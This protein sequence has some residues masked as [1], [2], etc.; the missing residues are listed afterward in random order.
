MKKKITSPKQLIAIFLATVGVLSM[1]LGV[2][3]ITSGG[4]S[5]PN[6]ARNGVVFIY[7]EFQDDAGNAYSA[8]GTGWAIGKPGKDVQYIVTNGHVVQYA[9]LTGGLI[10]VYFSVAENDF[11]VPQVVYYSDPA[12]KDVAIL[13]LPTATDKR[14]ALRL[15]A[16]DQVEAGDTAYALGYPGTSSQRQEYLTYD[17]SDITMT[18]G[19]VSKQMNPSGVGYSAFQMDTYIS[20]GNSGG[21]LVDEDG[22]VIGINTLGAIDPETGTELGMNYAIV[23]DELTKILDSEGMD[24]TMTGSGFGAPWM[25][26]LFL[27]LAVLT[28][29]GAAVLFMQEKKS[30]KISAATS[31]GAKNGTPIGRKPEGKAQAAKAEGVKAILR[32]VTGAYAGQTFDLTKGSVV[33]GRD[34]SACNIVF[35]KATP[36]ISGNHCQV[37]YDASKG[38]FLLTDHGSTYGTFLGNGKKLAAQVTEKL[39]AGDTFYLCDTANRFAVTKE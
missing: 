21:P 16:S 19:I 36:G 10:R 31:A 38:C 23:M 11:M 29:A 39:A 18:K 2:I 1:V 25:A 12:E 13:K 20:G 24:Y 30:G 5:S 22:N 9:Y 28:L 37:S 35:D 26:Y 15:K 17:E 33:L 27:P 6:E 32:G 8:T 4:K 7:T 14:T 34:P 3:G